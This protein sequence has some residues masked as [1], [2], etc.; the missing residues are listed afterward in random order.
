MGWVL[1]VFQSRKR[2]LMLTLEISCHCPTIV[3]LPA[4][5]SMESKRHTSY[6]S[7]STNIYSNEQHLNYWERLHALKLYSRHRLR[8]R[9]IMVYIWKITQHMVSTIDA[10]MGYKIKSRKHP[11]HGRECVIQ[12]QTNRNPGQSLQKNEITVFGPRLYNSLPKY[13][14]DIESVKTEKFKLEL[15][16]F[17]HLI[18]DEPK[19]PNYV[20]VS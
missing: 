16:K 1:R 17:L 8:E 6:R 15:D 7:Y 19:M 3:L 9:C 13:Q 20:T 12:T 14:T 4:L 11:R 10:T 18:S 2:S 5:E